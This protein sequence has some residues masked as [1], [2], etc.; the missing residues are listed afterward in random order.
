MPGRPSNADFGGT[1]TSLQLNFED[2]N[3]QVQQ[4]DQ[5]EELLFYYQY[6]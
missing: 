1:Q 3:E 4:I 2:L 5:E 6:L